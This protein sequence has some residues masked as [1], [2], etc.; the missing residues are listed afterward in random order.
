MSNNNNQSNECHIQR[1]RTET[2]IIQFS[3]V[4]HPHEVFCWEEGRVREV[5]QLFGGCVP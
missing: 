5:V 1:A 4:T 3:I 2:I